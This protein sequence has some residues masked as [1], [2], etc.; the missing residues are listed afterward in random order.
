VTVQPSPRLERLSPVPHGS[1]SDRELTALGLRR[2][3][4][5]DF[6]VNANPLGPS[7]LAIAAAAAA[8]WSHYPDDSA[9]SLRHVLAERDGVSPAEVVVGNGSA[10]LLWLL[11]LAFLDPGDAALVVGPTFGEYARCVAIA[12]GVT[13]EYRTERAAGFAVH[14]PALI[15]AARAAD[16]RV[17]FL[18]N[19]NNPTGTLLPVLALRDLAVALPDTLL[20]VDEAYR[21]FVDVPPATDCLL[22]FG[23]V[24][25]V[26]SL[27]KD[28]AMPGLRLG[29]ALAPESVR[30][31]LDAVRPPWS[32]N[33]VAQAAGQAALGDEAHLLAARRE[34]RWARAYLTEA[35]TRLGLHVLPAAA[36]FLLVEVVSGDR[37]R[38]ALLRR[39]LCVRDCASFGLP[40]YV[41]IGVRTMPE[42]ERLVAALAD[43]AGTEGVGSAGGEW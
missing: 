35:L 18:C 30:R 11:A 26:R 32:V 29:Y 39:G 34:V 36:N 17:A 15:A 22:A 9:T 43:L 23:N 12:G 21:Q 7:P 33:A 28:Y 41:R 2:D 20:V 40:A 42:C 27:T 14:P 4:V 25:L 31:A 13:R 24:V 8:T 1:I 37:V 6:S 16:V 5:V 10:E 19:P 3:E 38:A